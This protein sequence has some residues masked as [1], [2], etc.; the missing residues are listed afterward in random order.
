FQTSPMPP[1]GP[2]QESQRGRRGGGLPRLGCLGMLNPFNLLKLP[3]ITC[4][5]ITFVG[6]ILPI[7]LVI[8]LVA[9]IVLRPAPLW[10]ARV[11][12]M[13][14]DFESGQFGNSAS[15]EEG[16]SGQNKLLIAGGGI[17]RDDSISSVREEEI[18]WLPEKNVTGGRRVYVDI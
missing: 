10:K 11:D 9:L 1:Q 13:N 15:L 4:R 6:C 17:V 5:L 14:A 18:A 8:G 12:F 16:V 2:Q 7:L 3:G